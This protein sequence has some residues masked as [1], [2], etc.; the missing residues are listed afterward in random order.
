[1]SHRSYTD[2]GEP[3]SKLATYT[4][5]AELQDITAEVMQT[6]CPDIERGHKKWDRIEYGAD[7]ADTL[8]RSVKQL[9]QDLPRE[10]A[11]RE[12]ELARLTE[13]RVALQASLEKTRGHLAKAEAQREKTAKRLKRMRNYARRLA[14][15]ETE[16]AQWDIDASKAGVELEAMQTIWA[17]QNND[18]E[19]RSQALE[20]RDTAFVKTVD[21]A[22]DD[23]L[24][25]DG[26]AELWRLDAEC[27]RTAIAAEKA[28]VKIANDVL[29]EQKIDFE[30]SSAIKAK[31]Q[32]ELQA[33]LDDKASALR[34]AEDQVAASKRDAVAGSRALKL[35]LGELGAGTLKRG[36]NGKLEMQQVDVVKKA[37]QWVWKLLSPIVSEV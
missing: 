33:R 19:L 12:A 30:R 13:E 2:V 15:K 37:P 36:L 4:I 24:Q 9:H 31:K 6:Y 7:Y 3:V 23:K 16:L 34:I 1:V 35:V 32:N 17:A 5:A 14:K 20:A 28:Q 25:F 21:A 18:L 8:N 26:F 11:A 29:E 22:I 10:I 27:H